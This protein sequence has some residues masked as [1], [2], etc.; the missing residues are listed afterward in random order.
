MTC[1]RRGESVCVSVYVCNR[2]KN[3]RDGGQGHARLSGSGFPWCGS[4][5][6]R[7][8]WTDTHRTAH[9]GLLFAQHTREGSESQGGW[10]TVCL[11]KVNT[12]TCS[13]ARTSVRAHSLTH[14]HTEAFTVYSVRAVY[15]LARL[16][17]TQFLLFPF[18]P[19][20]LLLTLSHS[21]LSLSPSLSLLCPFSATVFSECAK[22]DYSK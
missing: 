13:C 17:Q 9:T 22:P 5:A 3:R 7:D 18:C 16:V 2:C 1:E 6:P 12:C 21:S 14:T 4:V 20:P 8:L 10:L 11:N 15:G 19:P